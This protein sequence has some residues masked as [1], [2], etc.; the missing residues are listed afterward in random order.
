MAEPVEL[1]L[2]R[3]CESEAFRTAPRL[4]D[5]LIFLVTRRLAGKMSGLKESVVGVEFFGRNPGYDPKKDPIVRVEAHRLRRRLF[6]YYSKHGLTDEWRIDV[7]KGTYAPVIRKASI[8]PVPCRLAVCVDADD[9]LISEGLTVELIGKL[10]ALP[11]VSVLAPRS[12][13][14]APGSLQ[15]AQELGANAILECRFDGMS[16]RARL[17]R[18]SPAGFVQ[19]GVFDNV[20]QPALDALASFVASSL[21]R[22]NA[23]ASGGRA[24][25]GRTRAI[26]RESYQ[27]YLSGRAWFHRWSP[28]NLAQ[29]A[30]KFEQVTKRCPDFAP[31]FAGLADCQV[32]LAYWHTADTRTTLER[33]RAYAQKAFDLEAGCAEA[34]CSLAAFKATLDRDWAGAEAD[35]MR[36]LEVNPNNTLALNRLAII[37]L[38]PQGRFEEAIDAVFSAYDLDPVSPEIG[39]EVVWVRICCRQFQESAEQG[40]R[41]IELHPN[42]LE[43]YWSLGLAE[44]ATGQYPAAREAME[45]AGRL[46]PEV[47]FTIAMRGFV[48][49]LA[50]NGD[51]AGQCLQQ[52]RALANVSPLRDLYFTWVYAGLNETDRAM[53][54]LERAIEASDPHALYIGVFFVYDSLRQHPGFRG[55][56]E[57]LCLS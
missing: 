51:A 21:G 4:R 45:I 17:C 15:G 43:G 12:S 49:G 38:A 5:F 18:S 27:I 13:I 55:L 3:I 1:Q 40:R 41:I 29:A 26:D 44:A 36:A 20:I 33:G 24:T 50:G 9:A 57:R 35:F 32:L 6:D 54:Y 42:F 47:P 19:I 23:M 30:A 2:A 56:Q 37:S 14:A 53:Q 10:G 31:A 34:Y 11:G 22:S 25:R 7:A 46:A 39:N 52:L 16:L 8:A 28:D 48:E